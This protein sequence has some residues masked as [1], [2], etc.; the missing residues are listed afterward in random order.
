MGQAAEARHGQAA[1]LSGAIMRKQ[2]ELLG[3]TIQGLL[4]AVLYALL[5]LV[6]GAAAT[7]CIAIVAAGMPGLTSMGAGMF[8]F[9]AVP[10][11]IL[12]FMLMVLTDR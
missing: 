3:E 4:A 12:V 10:A 8:A 6:I 2:S 11:A 5:A 7:A 1:A 9:C